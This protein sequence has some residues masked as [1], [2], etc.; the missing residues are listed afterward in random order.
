MERTSL[1]RCNLP[2]WVIASCEFNEDPEPIEIQGVRAANRFLFEA[3]ERED[4]AA[5]RAQRFDDWITVRFQLH[6]WRA[7]GT[8]TARRSLKN[9]YLRFL[10]GWGVDASSVEG[11]VLKAWV[12]SRLGLPPTFHRGR[13]DGD[14]GEAWGR[15]ARDRMLGS[16]RTS[17]IHDQLDLVYT[18]TQY[19]LARRRPGAR[20]VTLW[21]GVNDAAEHEVLEALGPREAIVRL[22]SLCSFT[23]DP[24]RAWEF[25]STVWE[26]R[27]ALARVFLAADVFPRAIL[28]GEREWIVVGGETKVRR[29]MG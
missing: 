14:D 5:A 29:V 21:R 10:R 28:R 11:A 20:W 25:G 1:N 19:E 15:Y 8:E 24:E 3:L 6:Q 17:A 26:A 27:I 13:I 4:D 16:A 23:D 22:N 18:Y 12:E 9:S 2:P 7:Q